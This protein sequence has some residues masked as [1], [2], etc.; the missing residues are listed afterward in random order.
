VPESEEALLAEQPVASAQ[1]RFLLSENP[2]AGQ[3]IV[4][5]KKA[6]KGS[7]ETSVSK[8]A[9]SLE[10]RHGVRAERTYEHALR[11]FVMR[12]SEE[13]ARA[14]AD[15]PDVA[16]VVEDSWVQTTTAQTGATWGLDRL[17]QRYRPLASTYTYNVTGRASPRPTRTATPPPPP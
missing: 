1:A 11:G 2:V 17:N 12:A 6:E 7:A 15:D 9:R 3:Y 16:Y 13:R 14:L 5:L 8:A 10:E 4:V